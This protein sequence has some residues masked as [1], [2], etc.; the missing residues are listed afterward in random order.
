MF[1]NAESNHVEPEQL[2]TLAGDLNPELIEKEKQEKKEKRRKGVL[3]HLLNTDKAAKKW[4]KPGQLDSSYADELRRLELA[5]ERRKKQMEMFERLKNRKHNLL[6][7]VDDDGT[8]R[9]EDCKS[10]IKKYTY[11]LYK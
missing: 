5:E 10:D 3:A 8:P 7:D 4:K 9:F 2:P 11:V 1:F 6:G